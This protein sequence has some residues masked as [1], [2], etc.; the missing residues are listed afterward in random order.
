[1]GR[2][3]IRKRVAFWPLFG[4][5]PQPHD[6]YH[7]RM[8]PLPRLLAILLLCV[9]LHVRA[10]DAPPEQSLYKGL[11]GNALE[12]VP[13]DAQARVRLQQANAVV[14]APMSAR[15]LAALTQIS[16]PVLLLGGFIWGVWSASQLEPHPEEPP[17]RIEPAPAPAPE[18]FAAAP[19]PEPQE[20]PRVFRVWLPQRST[21][22]GHH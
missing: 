21:A 16:N 19:A 10:V 12:L 3:H 4:A 22:S 15:T 13:M 14:S 2:N 20:R 6:P 7:A 9:P 1:M 18:S 11:V 5:L 8:P 17:A